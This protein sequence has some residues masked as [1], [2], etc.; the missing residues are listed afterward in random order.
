[1]NLKQL[2]E[3]TG[4]SHNALQETLLAE[5]RVAPRATAVTCVF[6]TTP[7]KTGDTAPGDL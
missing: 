7:S 5:E 1:M 4:E 2:P 6:P 3:N